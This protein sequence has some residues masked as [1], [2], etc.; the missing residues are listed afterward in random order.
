MIIEHG[1]QEPP[2][3]STL[4]R[5]RI[6][7]IG[8]VALLAAGVG[9]VLGGVL[10]AGQAVPLARAASYVPPDAVMYAEARLDL[11]GTQ[12]EYLRALLERFPSADAD[13]ILT[14]ALADTL[15]EALSDANSP[16]DYSNDVAPWFDGTFAFAMLDYP[17][18]ADPTNMRLPSVV[19]MFGVRDA[20]A[21]N[22]LIETLRAEA[23]GEG[24]S[25]T[26]SEHD[27]VMIWTLDVEP[28]EFAPMQGVGFAYA[29]TGDQLLFANG[30]DPI[31]A[32]LDA[33][34]GDSLADAD[35]VGPLLNVLP[36]ERSGTMVVNS[37]AMLA[38]LRAELESVQPGLADALAG[39]LDAVPPISVG[40]LAF[41]D[42]AVLMDGVSS[43]P[44]GPLAPA[45][46]Q[47]D[48][49]TRVPG[50]AIFF[51]D[52]SR[53][54][55][56]LEQMMV[57]LKAT[58]ALGPM[59]ESQLEELEGAEA[60]LGAELDEFVS[61]IGDGAMTAGWDGEAPYV[62]LV[63]RADD[64]DAA[65]RRLNQLGALAELAAGGSDMPVDIATET[66]DGVEVTRITYGD[67][68]GPD[69]GLLG[70][71]AVEY[72]LDGETAL[73][74][75]GRGFVRGAL[76]MDPADSLADGERYTAAIGRFGGSDN[77]GTFFVDL[78]ALRLAV[79]GAIPV[80]G[81]PEYAE[82]RPNL[83]PLDYVAGVTRV[84]GDRAVVRLGL[85]LR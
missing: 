44:E 32:A 27:G 55:P 77:A 1:Y 75:F 11:P 81:D 60:A 83:E 4:D 53:V 8:A 16:F 14:E 52:G 68:L 39:Y 30:A 85:V 64:P 45:N 46:S 66:V 36:E 84:D 9:V 62:G 49:A 21:A 51:A 65:A 19:G 12:R 37:A 54:G 13:A 22:E 5:A 2:Q 3:R 48:L 7:I 42:D 6:L 26:S 43:M 10:V 72:A 20:P 58:L 57:S 25:F 73:V 33:E 29:L 67:A 18:N 70:S 47:R 80:D 61:W 82:V 31:R 40:S 76:T 69:L 59:G 34:G 74:G 50:D 56:M 23:A 41:A 17:L 24:S 28:D 35:G 15:D 71:M 63:L 78:T 38:E 79:E